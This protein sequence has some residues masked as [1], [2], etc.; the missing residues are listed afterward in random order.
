[1]FSPSDFKTIKKIYPKD[2]DN[3][4]RDCVKVELA[5]HKGSKHDVV[6]KIYDKDILMNKDMSA[7]S[8]K[9]ALRRWRDEVKM[10]S[11]L[12]H[13]HIIQMYSHFEVNEKIY[14]VMEY[15]K[16]GNLYDAIPDGGFNGAHE[17]TAAKYIFQ[18]AD[19]L[20]Y[21]H[22][23]DVYHRDVKSSNILIDAYGDLKLCDFGLSAHSPNSRP[24]ISFC[25]TSYYMAPEMVRNKYRDVEH[26][27]AVD[28]WSLGVVAYEIL[29]GDFPFFSNADDEQEES[30]ELDYNIRRGTYT[31]PPRVPRGAGRLIGQLL[32]IGPKNRLSLEMVM[33]H[34]WIVQHNQ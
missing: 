34:P 7:T 2:D 3:D 23:K 13:P 1:R 29:T 18:I 17:Q 24:R 4:E 8:K 16:K 6:L 14:I 9:V 32:R 25:G 26:G 22:S 19:A 30:E 31:V 12:K 21:C 10:Q 5:K 27:K 15:A 28:L 20:H 33:S 11:L